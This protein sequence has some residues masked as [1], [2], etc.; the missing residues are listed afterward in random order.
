MKKLTTIIMLA[1]AL[2]GCNSQS[3]SS[4]AE[5]KEAKQMLQGVWVDAETGDVSFQVKGESWAQAHR[6]LLLSN[7][8]ICSGSQTRMV[9]W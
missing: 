8:Q 2:M 4:P 5:S 3:G 9:I 6:M 7:R 1:A